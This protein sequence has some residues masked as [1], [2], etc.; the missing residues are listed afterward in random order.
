MHYSRLRAGRSESDVVEGRR[1]RAL[2]AASARW[3][4]PRFPS[5]ERAYPERPCSTE[6]CSGIIREGSR[7][8]RCERCKYRWLRERAGPCKIAGCVKLAIGGRGWC[9]HHYKRWRKWGDPLGSKPE[10]EKICETCSKS[11]LTPNSRRRFCSQKCWA[12]AARKRWPEDT[13]TPRR[14]AAYQKRRALKR[15]AEAE[16]ILFDEIKARD[17]NRCGLCGKRVGS[18]SYP[19]RLS[20]SLDHILPLSEGGAHVAANVQ[21]AHLRCNLEKGNRARDEQLRL[22]G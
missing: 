20:A 19:H 17:G 6:G 14:K 21:L 13:W 8:S 7:H 22:V 10:I 18:K 3:A 2:A 9:D 5:A 15:T 4:Q 12:K 16:H 11:F 1:R